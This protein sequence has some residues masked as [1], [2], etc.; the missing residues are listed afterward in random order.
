MSIPL[1]FSGLVRGSYID[2][3]QEP[4]IVPVFSKKAKTEFPYITHPPLKGFL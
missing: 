3:R 1:R 2:L 4:F